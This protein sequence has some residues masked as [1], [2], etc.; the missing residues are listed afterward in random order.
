M[1]SPISNAIPAALT[2]AVIAAWLWLRSATS[3]ATPPAS[4]AGPADATRM[5]RSA[6]SMSR[7]PR[8][9]IYP[10]GART[11]RPAHPVMPGGGALLR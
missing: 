11:G 9:E 7:R 4:V 8:T 10:A 2:I 6:G 1:D 3:Q 5:I